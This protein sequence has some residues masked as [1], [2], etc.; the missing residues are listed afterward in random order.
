MSGI[1]DFLGGVSA[2]E[3]NVDIVFVI[4]ATDSMKPIIDKVKESTLHFHEQLTKV[5]EQTGK[6]VSKL[7][8]KVN[9]FRDFYYDGNFAYGESDFFEL[10][11]QEEDFKDFVS[12]IEA[13]GG[14]DDPETS[15]EALALAMKTNWVQD[16]ARKR[17]IIVLFTDASAHQFE[18]YENLKAEAEKKGCSVTSYPE[19]MPKS[20]EEFFN[21]WLCI[22]EEQESLALNQMSK[23]GRRLIIYAPDAYPWSDMAATLNLV[24]VENIEEKSGGSTIEMDEVMSLIGFSMS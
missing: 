20:L 3:T 5:L 2:I 23:T 8:V 17:H 12:Q 6:H 7:R 10:P 13:K 16:G 15:L 11:G 19:G 21:Q 9:W 1:Q 18:E 22:D 4:D 14:G 24:Q